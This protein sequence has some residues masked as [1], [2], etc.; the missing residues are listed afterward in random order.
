MAAPDPD[1]SVCGPKKESPS[2][3]DEE[4]EHAGDMLLIR[5]LLTVALWQPRKNI[6]YIDLLSGPHQWHGMGAENLPG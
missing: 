1:A 4:A 6:C 2:P 5:A 3:G